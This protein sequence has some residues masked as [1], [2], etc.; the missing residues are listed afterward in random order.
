MIFVISI[1]IFCGQIF[2]KILKILLL[3]ITI[4]PLLIVFVDFLILS[5][6]SQK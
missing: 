6:L 2:V 4:Y 3:K 5:L 1:Q